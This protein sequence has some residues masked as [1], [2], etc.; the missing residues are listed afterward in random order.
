MTLQG[1]KEQISK[2]LITLCACL[3]ITQ[4]WFYYAAQIKEG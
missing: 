2:L 1:E 3:F 4:H